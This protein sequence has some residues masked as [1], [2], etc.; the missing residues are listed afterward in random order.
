MKPGLRAVSAP[1]AL[2]V[3]FALMTSLLPE[4]VDA[5]P[6]AF[7]H[8]PIRIVGDSDFSSANGVVSGSG[9]GSDPY[10]IELWQIGPNSGG[11]GLAIWDSRAHVIIRNTV[12]FQCNVGISLGNATDVRI[13]NC[14]FL[15]NIVGVTTFDCDDIKIVDSIFRENDY[16]IS[17]TYSH[18][19]RDNN[20]YIDNNYTL[21]KKVQP[22][23][24]GPLGD[25]ICYSL[26]IMLVAVIAA[27]LFFRIKHGP[28]RPQ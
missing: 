13:D 3:M 2:F 17:I 12:F 8:P 28:K 6:D 9:T 1:I 25:A 20:E 24:Q 14:A 27:L 15:R 5:Q 4:R 19:A 22:W 16:A 10:I 18:V 26:L 21:I 7:G 11:T 23:E